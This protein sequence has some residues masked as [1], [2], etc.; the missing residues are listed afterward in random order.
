M[1][2]LNQ[3]QMPDN[4]NVYDI[5]N[6]TNIYFQ[7]LDED[8]WTMTKNEYTKDITNEQADQAYRYFSSHWMDFD[9]D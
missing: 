4:F 1:S 9:V 2:S 5:D 7:R 6:R 8:R 3:M